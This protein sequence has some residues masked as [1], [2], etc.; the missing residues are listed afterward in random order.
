MVEAS[1][2]RG[3][4]R[5]EREH[6][7]T[8]GHRRWE[9]VKGWGSHTLPVNPNFPDVDVR[10]A[11]EWEELDE[12]EIVDYVTNEEVEAIMRELPRHKDLVRLKGEMVTQSQ[13]QQSI[14]NLRT[15][16]NRATSTMAQ[17]NQH[18]AEISKADFEGLKSRVNAVG[19]QLQNFQDVKERMKGIDERIRNAESLQV[20]V[21]EL[22]EKAKLANAK[23]ESLKVMFMGLTEDAINRTSTRHPCV[24]CG[25]VCQTIYPVFRWIDAEDA[26]R[27]IASVEV[28]DA[29]NAGDQAYIRPHKGDARNVEKMVKNMQTRWESIGLLKPIGKEAEADAT[30][31]SKALTEAAED[32]MWKDHG[33][34]QRAT[35]KDEP[36]EP[37]ATGNVVPV[38]TGTPTVDAY[39]AHLL[40]N[41]SMT[42]SELVDY[43]VTLGLE[44]V[45]A[46][47]IITCGLAEGW[48]VKGQ[49]PARSETGRGRPRVTIVAAGKVQA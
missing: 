18:A 8:T 38:S 44:Q 26:F 11:P 19:N 24:F 35:S 13:F 46:D 49:A 10:L 42:R 4:Q 2:S 14:S 25:K 1:T 32:F 17:H 28:C 16:L 29:C 20:K 34:E 45:H 23:L 3:I 9:G 43:G 7:S 12:H 31:L 37:P 22:A 48:L 40:A 36:A 15:D 39:K 33:Y 5:G 27:R 41:T 21:G 30:A 47:A 6:W